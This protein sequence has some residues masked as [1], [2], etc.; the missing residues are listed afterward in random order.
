MATSKNNNHSKQKASSK[1]S[2]AER[3]SASTTQNSSHRYLQNQQVSAIESWKDHIPVARKDSVTAEPEQDD[4]VVQAYL[5]A[6]MAL[7]DVMAPRQHTVN[8]S[9]PVMR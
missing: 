6:K 2:N 3:T 8:G 7:F 9:M 5:K 1:S 4:A